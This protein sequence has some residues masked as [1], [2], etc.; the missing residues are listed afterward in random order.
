MVLRF[1]RFDYS[2]V[3]RIALG[4]AHCTVPSDQ[5][6]NKPGVGWATLRIGKHVGSVNNRE[7]KFSI[8][9]QCTGAMECPNCE[10]AARPFGASE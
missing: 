5:K 3:D 10:Y 4:P 6:G 8:K 9:L 2:F 1:S 7:E